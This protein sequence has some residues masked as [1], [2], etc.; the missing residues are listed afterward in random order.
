MTGTEQHL[1]DFFKQ[2][3][4]I[5]LFFRLRLQSLS[6]VAVMAVNIYLCLHGRLLKVWM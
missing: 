2:A 3:V 1:H 4:P 5:L 6:S